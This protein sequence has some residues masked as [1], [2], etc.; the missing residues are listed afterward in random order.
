LLNERLT[1]AVGS[2]F[3]LEGAKNSSQKASDII[4]NLSLNYAISRDGR[5]M[6]RFYR[7]NEYEGIGW[8][9]ILLKR[10]IKFYNH[11]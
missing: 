4:G 3:E 7:R 9:D 2:N 6:L 1:V 11:G 10:A 5:Y 8:T